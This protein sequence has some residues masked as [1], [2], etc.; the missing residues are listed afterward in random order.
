MPDVLDTLDWKPW[1]KD[2]EWVYADIFGVAR[3]G[4]RAG[5][6]DDSTRYFVRALDDDGALGAWHYTNIERADAVRILDEAIGAL[7]LQDAP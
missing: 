2:P 4:K 1:P 6:K 7:A 3:V 5:K